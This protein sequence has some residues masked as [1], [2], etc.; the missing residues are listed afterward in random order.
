MKCAP[1]CYIDISKKANKPA[2]GSK[3]LN[4]NQLIGL[5][6]CFPGSSTK[7]S[8]CNIDKLLIQELFSPVVLTAA[9]WAN[10]IKQGSQLKQGLGSGLISTEQA[11]TE[12]F[13]VNVL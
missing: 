6:H 11:K 9:T 7:V 12:Q 2:H 3:D 4:Y 10:K 8:D 5:A 1:P 13:E